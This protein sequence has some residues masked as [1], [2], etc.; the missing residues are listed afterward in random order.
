MNFN[1][2]L[3]NDELVIDDLDEDRLSFDEE[4]Q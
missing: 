3:N 1:G 4:E 2:Q